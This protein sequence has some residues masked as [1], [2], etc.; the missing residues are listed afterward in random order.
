[1]VR[2][3]FFFFGVGVI[4][5]LCCQDKLGSCVY[6]N[7]CKLCHIFEGIEDTKMDFKQLSKFDG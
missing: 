7:F 6:V 2:K 3:G 5:E 1:M 4:L